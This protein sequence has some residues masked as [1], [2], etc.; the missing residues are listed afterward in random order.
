MCH[1]KVSTIGWKAVLM[2][3]E[4]LLCFQCSRELVKINGAICQ[5]CGR[6]GEFEPLCKD[7]LRWSMDPCWKENEMI[8]R[9]IYQYNEGI[10]TIFNQFKFRGDF[11]LGKVFSKEIR[12][13]FIKEFTSVSMISFIPLSEERLYERGFNQAEILAKHIP[14]KIEPTLL[15]KN[16]TKQSKKTRQERLTGDNPFQLRL[17]VNITA[18]HI[19]L[20]D[21]IYTTGTTIRHAAKLLLENGASKVSSLTLIRS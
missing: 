5:G 20:I 14:R 21:D 9:S 3:E 13:F 11:E 8:N 4:P 1:E 15:K 17:N 7:C 16:E 2:V 6:P 19:L 10:K 12:E 18:Q